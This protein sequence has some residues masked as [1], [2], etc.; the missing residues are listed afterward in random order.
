M[1]KRYKEYEFRLLVTPAL[2][3][4]PRAALKEIM[5]GNIAYALLTE[6]NKELENY[7]WGN[8]EGSSKWVCC[9]TVL[10]FWC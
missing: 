4:T 7:Y 9:I 6:K 1:V 10:H 8:E 5:D 2:A 3:S